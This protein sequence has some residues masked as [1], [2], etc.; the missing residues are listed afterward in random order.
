MQPATENQPEHQS[1]CEEFE[2][3]KKS[4]CEEGKLTLPKVSSSM[5][6]VKIYK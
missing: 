3:K 2:Q 4:K 1:K 5:G 6:E